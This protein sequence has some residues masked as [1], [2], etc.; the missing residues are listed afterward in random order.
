MKFGDL[1]VDRNLE[2]CLIALASQKHIQSL[3][4]DFQQLRHDIE[5]GP[6]SYERLFALIHQQYAYRLGKPR[7]GDQS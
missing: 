3:E 7:W 1:G 2:R 6:R 4:L 5:S